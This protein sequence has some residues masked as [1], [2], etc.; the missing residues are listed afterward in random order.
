MSRRRK[1]YRAGGE[2]STASPVVNI[3]IAP[4]MLFVGG[5][6][7]HEQISARKIFG[8]ALCMAGVALLSLKD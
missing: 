1:I 8:A 7:Y 5:F 4:V 3:L 6:F 2:L